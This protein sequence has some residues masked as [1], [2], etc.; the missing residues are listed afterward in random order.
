MKMRS[1]QCS[2]PPCI[3]SFL[4][5]LQFAEL[6]C[7]PSCL[8]VG[9][10]RSGRIVDDEHVLVLSA[11][12]QVRPSSSI[13]GFGDEVVEREVVVIASLTLLYGNGLVF[14]ILPVAVITT[15]PQ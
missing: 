7:Y 13:V 4:P 2:L 3:M 5:R 10:W 12:T 1:R 6:W 11:Q 8:Q 15:I 14:G 9:S